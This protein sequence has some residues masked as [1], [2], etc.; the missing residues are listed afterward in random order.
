MNNL[1]FQTKTLAAVI[2]LAARMQ[3]L[4]AAE[5][6]VETEPWLKERLEWFQDQKFGLMMHWGIESERRGDLRHPRR[7][8]LQRRQC[9]F[10]QKDK[11]VYAIY[12]PH[13]EGQGLPSQVLISGIKPKPGSKLHLLGAKQ[14]I[15]W[16][17]FTNGTTAIYV[18]DEVVRSSSDQHAFSFMLKQ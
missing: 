7:R 17:T 9:R 4:T 2:C 12:L 3:L 10:T 18:P 8:A 14:P 5:T 6:P 13:R 15:K 1:M 16:E 11:T